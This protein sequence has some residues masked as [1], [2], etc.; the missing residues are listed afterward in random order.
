MDVVLYPHPAVLPNVDI[1]PKYCARLNSLG[2][3]SVNVL[4][5]ELLH[6]IFEVMPIGKNSVRQNVIYPLLLVCREW[7]VM[8][9]T[10]ESLSSMLYSIIEQCIAEPILWETLDIQNVHVLRGVAYALHA[11]YVRSHPT[12]RWAQFIKTVRFKKELSEIIRDQ[13][14]HN[15]HMHLIVRHAVN[16]QEFCLPDQYSSNTL[17]LVS[18]LHGKTLTKLWV[19]VRGANMEPLAY[20]DDMKSLCHLC[21]VGDRISAPLDITSWTLPSLTFFVWISVPDRQL[22]YMRFFTQSNFPS[23]KTFRLLTQIQPSPMLESTFTAFMQS[24][25]HVDKLELLMSPDTYKSVLPHV[26]ARCLSIR[27]PK[28][29]LVAYLP[30]AVQL[31]QFICHTRSSEEMQDI[32]NVFNQLLETPKP[33]KAIGLSDSTF[34]FAWLADDD[35][36]TVFGVNK[37]ELVGKAVAYLRKGLRILDSYD[38]AVDDYFGTK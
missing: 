19:A 5:S 1:L 24:K 17:S 29:A 34:R 12:L 31:L 22:D 26:S 7:K 16:V 37:D 10:S 30:P 18:A 3:M 23:L 2:N 11:S 32:Y 20:I 33:L 36:Q 38:R 8:S 27:Q 28:P 35:S 4:S 13:L 15:E 9:I 6:A 21:V 14:V 25:A